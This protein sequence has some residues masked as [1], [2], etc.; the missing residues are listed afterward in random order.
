VLLS[1]AIELTEPAGTVDVEVRP[2][3]GHV[4]RSLA[5]SKIRLDIVM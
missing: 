4:D 2:Q 3:G 5:V 1:N